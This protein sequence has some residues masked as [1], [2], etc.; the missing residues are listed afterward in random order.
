MKNEPLLMRVF[1]LTT[2]FAAVSDSVSLHSYLIDFRKSDGVI[3]YT[4]LQIL[5]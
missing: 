4:C 3:P 1:S 2:T 5:T